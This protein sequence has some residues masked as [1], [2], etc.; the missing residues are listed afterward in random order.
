MTVHVER[1]KVIT[2][3]NRRDNRLVIYRILRIIDTIA[4]YLT[5]FDIIIEIAEVLRNVKDILVGFSE[6]LNKIRTL[7]AVVRIVEE[8]II[9]LILLRRSIRSSNLRSN[10]HGSGGNN[11]F[12]F[13]I[14]INH[15]WDT[16][17]RSECAAV[18]GWDMAWT[19]NFLYVV[20]NFFV[21]SNNV[22]DFWI[23]ASIAVVENLR[24][25]GETWIVHFIIYY[26][27]CSLS[28]GR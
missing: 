14:V 12:N 11:C 26:C 8:I 5:S 18:A 13:I 24:L 10:F 22:I 20:S 19:S 21:S 23:V 2:S 3:S 6:L 27:Y 1:F 9:T 7:T 25:V 4:V 28:V 16:S 17:Y 15:V